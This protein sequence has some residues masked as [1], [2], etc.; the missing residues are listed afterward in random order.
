M[1]KH[2]LVPLDG[3]ILA[4]CVLPHT[5]AFAKAFQAKVTLVRVLNGLANEREDLVDLFDWRL[6]KAEA[7][8][9][10]DKVARYLRKEGMNIDVAI[11]EGPTAERI[12]EYAAAKQADFIILSSHGLS[13]YSG[14]NISSVVQQIIS[15]AYLPVLI[16][17]ADSTKLP[18]F[19]A[20]Q[21][22]K[23]LVP[24]D[25]SARAECALSAATWIA[26]N[27][28]SLLLPLHL[29]AQPEMPRRTPLTQ[30]ELLL[31]GDLV[32]RNRNEATHYLKEV[33]YRLT[34]EEFKIAP[35]VQVCTSTTSAI[36]DIVRREKIDLVVL[37]AHGYSSENKWPFGSVAMNLIVF[38]KTPLL[39]V[40]DLNFSDSD[41]SQFDDS[42]QQ[43]LGH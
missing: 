18:N 13:G 42:Q 12:M 40:Q 16:V 30:E 36:H 5:V 31:A 17:R 34:C 28:N 8:L 4:E 21:Y 37:C 6:E 23:I 39:I 22:K 41:I 29:V 3:S 15:Q 27:H 10:L 33:C 38:G 1:F 9:Y 11:L 25:L 19:K 32:D 14:W 26:R 20:L 35:L 24:L 2:V 43:R 7:Q